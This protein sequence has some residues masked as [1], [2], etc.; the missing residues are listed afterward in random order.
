MKET[1]DMNI[2]RTTILALLALSSTACGGPST[3]PPEP[4]VILEELPDMTQADM[5]LPDVSTIDMPSLE[6]MTEPP[7][8]RTLQT[9]ELWGSEVVENLVNDPN[10]TLMHSDYSTERWRTFISTRTRSQL[11]QSVRKVLA[12][13]PGGPFAATLWTP[14][15]MQPEPS[16]RIVQ[17]QVFLPTSSNT[18][19]IWVGRVTESLRGND[20]DWPK[21]DLVGISPDEMATDVYTELVYMGESLVTDKHTW[22]RYG[23]VSADITGQAIFEILDASELELYL[24]APRIKTMEASPSALTR[25]LEAGPRPASKWSRPRLGLR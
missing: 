8:P 14:Y 7:K 5:N 23:G 17:G 25:P 15:D 13:A 22:R 1:H 6:D 9:T 20:S 21:L 24:H 11:S 12:D 19:S 4:V 3:S 16:V 18:V 2:Q 10:F